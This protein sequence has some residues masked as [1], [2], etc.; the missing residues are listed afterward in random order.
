MRFRSHLDPTTFVTFIHVDGTAYGSEFEK[1]ARSL[2]QKR[3]EDGSELFAMLRDK[4]RRV[5]AHER[6][7]VWQGLRL[8][9][10][11]IYALLTYSAAVTGF[12]KY[13][14]ITHDWRTWPNISIQQRL[15][16]RLDKPFWIYVN[17]EKGELA[18]G[19]ER[20]DGYQLEV[21]I[22]TKE[23]LETSASI[24]DFQTWQEDRK[25]IVDPVHF[26]RWRKRNPAYLKLYDFFAKFVGSEQ[27]ALRTL[28]PLINASF[29]TSIPEK[30]LAELLARMWARLR[31]PNG[32]Y[33]AF[34]EQSEPCRW[35]DLFHGW[36]KE[37][38][39]TTPFGETPDLVDLDY[40][41]FYYM[42]GGTWLGSRLAGEM[43]H[44]FLGPLALEWEALSKTV[45]GLTYYLD[46]PIYVTNEDAHNLAFNTDRQTRI[47]RFFFEDQ[48]DRVF[49]IGD[50]N[51]G[52]VFLSHGFAKMDQ[53]DFRGFVVDTLAAYGAFR[54]ASGIQLTEAGR[55]CYHADCPH[56]TDNFCNSYPLIPEKFEDCGFEERL[57]SWINRIRMR[58]TQ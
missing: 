5:M 8:P 58:S 44:P 38:E 28:I 6:Y 27:L 51:L 11:Y 37:L 47:F 15:F 10:L 23:M 16:N 24:N 46:Y 32:E 33:S 1:H 12:I 43:T 7:H 41:H 21:H 55:T 50:S 52:S 4:E 34:L 22:T 56:Y 19:S 57:T 31:E 53:S 25:H 17:P 18:Y 48:H 45:P 26:S 30:A 13:A 39:Y 42:S 2:Q 20:Q 9:F 3:G 49:T 35:S 36:L 40:E 14:Q 54:R 29:H